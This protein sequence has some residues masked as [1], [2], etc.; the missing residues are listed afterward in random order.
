MAFAAQVKDHIVTLHSTIQQ[1]SSA[2]GFWTYFAFFQV[3]PV[4]PRD[5][6]AKGSGRC[7]GQARQRGLL[8]VQVMFVVGFFYWRRMQEQSRKLL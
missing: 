2:F 7:E 4:G 1:S 5:R 3:N 6:R 8:V